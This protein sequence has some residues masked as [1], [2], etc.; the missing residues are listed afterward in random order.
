MMFIK[1]AYVASNGKA[2]DKFEE[3]WTMEREI[4]FPNIKMLDSLGRLTV[5][6]YRTE[7]FIVNNPVEAQFVSALTEYMWGVSVYDR[8]HVTQD[9]LI[10]SD[11]GGQLWC[12]TYSDAI[13]YEWVR[14][15]IRSFPAD[16]YIRRLF[17][18]K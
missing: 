6:P 3:A 17:N 15:I 12:V 18:I 11:E 10:I 1:T 14:E 5:N 4:S 2:F 8:N 13:M 16:S 7:C 9:S